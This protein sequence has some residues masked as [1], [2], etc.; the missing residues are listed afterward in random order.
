[1]KL[2]KILVKEFKETNVELLLMKIQ[3]QRALG[4]TNQNTIRFNARKNKI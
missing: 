3:K 4:I 2:S 1:M